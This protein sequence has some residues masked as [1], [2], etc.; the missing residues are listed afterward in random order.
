MDNWGERE[1]IKPFSK[2]KKMKRK[3]SQPQH[4][5]PRLSEKWRIFME[6]S[7]GQLTP[8]PD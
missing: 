4:N 1:N 6:G 7:T 8:S 5:Q 3:R 2:G